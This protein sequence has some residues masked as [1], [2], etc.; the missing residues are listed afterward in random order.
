[1]NRITSHPLWTGHAG[2]GRDYLRLLSLGIRAVVQLA[3]EEPP[4]QPLRDLVYLRFPLND[5]ADNP[6]DLLALAVGSLASLLTLRVPTLV[7][8][9]AGMS[10]SPAVAAF[11]LS[12]VT[13]EPPE[14]VLK[15]IVSG[16]RGDVSPG[17]WGELSRSHRYAPRLVSPLASPGAAS[18]GRI[19]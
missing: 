12:L 17:L 8:C 13:G 16:R 19:V 3:A 1:M 5:G 15:R 7:C 6:A 11:A 10:R 14:D 2:D 18:S 9:G 4:L